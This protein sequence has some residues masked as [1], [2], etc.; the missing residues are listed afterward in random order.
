M[1]QKKSNWSWNY[2]FVL[3]R[4]L[5]LTH[6]RTN[7]QPNTYASLPCPF[8]SRHK[9]SKYFIINIDFFFTLSPFLFSFALSLLLSLNLFSSCIRSLPYWCL[10]YW[11]RLFFGE[12]KNAF[13]PRLPTYKTN[14]AS[15]KKTKKK[16]YRNNNG[17][18]CVY[19]EHRI[20]IWFGKFIINFRCH[21]PC[22]GFFA[23]LWSPSHSLS[24]VRVCCFL[25]L[26]IRRLLFDWHEIVRYV[27]CASMCVCVH[28][29]SYQYANGWNAMAM[30][31]WV[32]ILYSLE[33]FATH[34]FFPLLH[35]T[36]I[37]EIKFIW[38]IGEAH[39]NRTLFFQSNH[40][41]FDTFPSMKW[42]KSR[43]H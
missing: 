31:V 23:L 10:E 32:Q 27:F 4:S 42:N 3:A 25:S 29:S 38:H 9:L 35:I 40:T 17:N 39:E 41:T 26:F 43:N 21:F 30:L 11:I 15:E 6:T 28:E 1:H 34:T 24:C 22:T 5:S 37:L 19:I 18:E 2:G 33:A 36:K 20:K 14:N 16:K 8:S 13:V 12:H 7:I